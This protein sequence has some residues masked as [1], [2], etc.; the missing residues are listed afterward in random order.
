MCYK[1]LIIAIISFNLLTINWVLASS[2]KEARNTQ[3]KEV[4]VRLSNSQFIYPMNIRY[5]VFSGKK[6][7]A[8]GAIKGLSADLAQYIYINQIPSNLPVTID[9]Y[10]M[11]V[12]NRTVFN[13]PCKLTLTPNQLRAN[14]SVGFHGDIAT[15]GSFTC[16][17]ST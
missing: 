5:R 14:I 1:K 15:H 11:N 9:I 4:E 10:K 8:A 13:D 7:Y 16:M 6:C 2:N 17:V 12:G 3:V